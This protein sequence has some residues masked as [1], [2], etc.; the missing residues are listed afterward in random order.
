MLTHGWEGSLEVM[1]LG[2]AWWSGGV[3]P[4]VELL[5]GRWWGEEAEGW[6]WSEQ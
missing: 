5:S 6:C 1:G 2:R 4:W 3:L